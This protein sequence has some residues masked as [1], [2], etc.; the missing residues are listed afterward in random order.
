VRLELASIG[1]VPTAVKARHPAAI[2]FDLQKKPPLP[3][4]GGP[5]GEL[6]IAVIAASGFTVIGYAATAFPKAL[7]QTTE[8][9][10]T[11]SNETVTAWLR[12]RR[13][14]ASAVL[15]GNSVETDVTA[16]ILRFILCTP[17][18]R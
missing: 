12:P 14:S 13:G 6:R 5:V 3:G 18:T 15:M 1:D 4:N 17:V 9:P 11:R 8:R 7:N 2:A 10:A 16:V